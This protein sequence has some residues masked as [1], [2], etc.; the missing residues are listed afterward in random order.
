MELYRSK[1]YCREGERC[2]VSSHSMARPVSPPARSSNS[3][4]RPA[5][6]PSKKPKKE[7]TDETHSIGSSPRRELRREL[8]RKIIK[9]VS[10]KSKLKGLVQEDGYWSLNQLMSRW[11]IM[12]GH[13]RKDIV[14]AIQRD[15]FAST[16]P[17]KLRFAL[18]PARGSN[19]TLVRVV[20]KE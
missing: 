11:A 7:S 10:D 4:S 2:G 3:P 8:M 15:L 9:T 18:K 6:P 14:H 17:S 16:D 12:E 1:W 19:D 13:T 5:S 20:P